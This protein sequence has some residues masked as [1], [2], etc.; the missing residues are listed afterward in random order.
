MIVS[1]VRVSLSQVLACGDGRAY[2]VL[3][4]PVL[5]VD[6]VIGRDGQ[7]G[8]RRAGCRR[9]LDHHTGFGPAVGGGFLGGHPGNDFA[10]T[11]KCLV[12][13]VELVGACPDVGTGTVDRERPR[14]VRRRPR[15]AGAP[16]SVPAHGVGSCRRRRHHAFGDRDVVERR[17]VERAGVWEVTNRPTARRCRDR[18]WPS[19]LCPGLPVGG[20]VA[21]DDVAVRGSA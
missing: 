2:G 11:G 1:P 7:Q 21:G 5:E 3:V 6:P 8:I 15:Q 18:L 20:G 12:H 19:D 4:E 14:G 9:L 10:V 17:R 16:T 13:E